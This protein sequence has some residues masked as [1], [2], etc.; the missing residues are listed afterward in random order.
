MSFADKINCVPKYYDKIRVKSSIIEG[1]FYLEYRYQPFSE[2]FTGTWRKVGAHHVDNPSTISFK[3]SGCVSH[4]D[5][6]PEKRGIQKPVSYQCV[7]WSKKFN[8]YDWS[9]GSCS[10]N[11]SCWGVAEYLFE[12]KMQNN[13]NFQFSHKKIM[14]PD[15]PGEEVVARYNCS[16]TRKFSPAQDK[17][18][19]QGVAMTSRKLKMFYPFIIDG[20]PEATYYIYISMQPNDKLPEDR[21]YLY[22]VNMSTWPPQYQ[23]GYYQ[24]PN[25]MS[26][27]YFLESPG[28]P[29]PEGIC[30]LEKHHKHVGSTYLELYPGGKHII[31]SFLCN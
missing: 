1:E 14:N 20:N 29:K 6:W 25:H 13:I 8:K 5:K 12:L 23:N 15:L 27:E 26:M 3:C 16:L 17:H 18:F 10:N 24:F 9:V 28:L 2:D 30:D 4:S 19:I 21:R 22:D 7:G 11:A 31:S